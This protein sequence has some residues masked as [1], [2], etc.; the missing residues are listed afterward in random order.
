MVVHAHQDQVFGPHGVPPSSSKTDVLVRLE[1]KP[2]PKARATNHAV[3]PID[4]RAGARAACAVGARA[5]DQSLVA[6]ALG[7]TF[8]LGTYSS[9]AIVR[10]APGYFAWSAATHSGHGP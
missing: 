3:Q 6:T 8:I 4:A 1:A 5:G 7:V 10:G 9:I 2:T